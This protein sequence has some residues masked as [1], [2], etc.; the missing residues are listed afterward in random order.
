LSVRDGWKAD[1]ACGSI[2]L[3]R[4][5]LSSLLACVILTP[6]AHAEPNLEKGF[7]AAL[8]GCEEWLL[9]PASWA[10]G[11]GPFI[12]A[13]GLGDQMRLVE[14]VAEANLPPPAM[15]RANQYWRINST[16]VAGY[17]LIVSDQLPMCHVTGGGGS[18][19][20]PSV[21]RVLSSTAF[22]RRWEQ[23]R[24]SR[25]GGM[26][27]ATFRNRRDSALSIIIS[28]AREP[29]QRMNRVQVVATA[30]YRTTD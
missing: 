15:R 23:Q 8:R 13:V 9:N 17:V 10:E 30:T 7:D 18:D 4:C 1:I 14:R 11:T 16:P 6:S 26:T 21:E 29:G 28:R 2:Q 3:M 22:R 24:T 25:K 27:T 12:A 20:Q 19:L 5:S